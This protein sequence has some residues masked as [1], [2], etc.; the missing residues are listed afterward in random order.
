VL[1][2]WLR[3]GGVSDAWQIAPVLVGAGLEMSALGP[4]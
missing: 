3:E 1:A 4:K 2:A